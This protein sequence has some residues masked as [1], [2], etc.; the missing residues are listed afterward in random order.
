M[1][2]HANR[3]IA[4]TTLGIMMAGSFGGLGTPQAQA[5]S[6]GRRNTMLGLGAV[7][8]YGLLTHRRSLA[9]AGA[10]GTGIAYHNMRVAKQRENRQAAWR[11]HHRRHRHRS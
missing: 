8:A 4:L 10:V 6:K 9:V 3:W 1:H 5:G 2:R 11:R 7:T